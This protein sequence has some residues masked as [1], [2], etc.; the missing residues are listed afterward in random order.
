[1]LIRSQPLDPSNAAKLS[2][3]SRSEIASNSKENIV[4]QHIGTMSDE[5]RTKIQQRPD[6][7]QRVKM[8]WI[9]L[10]NG[11]LDCKRTL[12]NHM[13]WHRTMKK[14]HPYEGFSGLLRVMQTH[15]RHYVVQEE[16]FGYAEKTYKQHKIGTA[17]ETI[18]LLEHMRE[19]DEYWNR[20]RKTVEAKYPKYKH[21]ITK[22]AAGSTSQSGDFVPQG[23]GWVGMESGKD[24]QEGYF[25]LINGR[26]ELSDSPDP[27]ETDHLLAELR[28]YYRDTNNAYKMA[29]AD[30]KKDFE[31]LNQLLQENLYSWWD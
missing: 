17:K 8:T 31:K 29:E 16:K 2:K 28:N 14:I 5:F 10:K 18:R 7:G 9:R 21:L 1:M 24:P 30:S 4:S 11:Y 19:P 27:K 12:N 6:V 23:N 22:Y 20:R 25:E 15:L 26:F 3:D 13:K